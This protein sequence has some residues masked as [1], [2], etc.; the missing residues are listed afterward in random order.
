[1]LEIHPTIRNNYP[2]D[3]WN[4]KNLKGEMIYEKEN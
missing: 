2:N 4:I 1:M 3:I